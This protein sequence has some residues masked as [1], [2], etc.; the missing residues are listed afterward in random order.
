L[1]LSSTAKSDLLLLVVTLLAAIS[2]M[3]SREAVSLMPPLLFI[4]V[5]FLLGGLVL[6][7]AG[8]RELGA[9][10]RR[11]CLRA[12]RVGLVFGLAMSCWVNGLFRIDH[13]GEGSR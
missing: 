10:S 13:V 7:V 5:R 11:Q 1:P 8:R 2:W 12:V 3:F 4:S 9:L 6:G